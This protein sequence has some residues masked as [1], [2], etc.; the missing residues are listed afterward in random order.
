MKKT[1]IPIF[2]NNQKAFVEAYLI[3]DVPSDMITKTNLEWA[4]TKQ[5]HQ[6]RCKIRGYP[7]PE[8]SHWDWEKKAK[9]LGLFGMIQTLFGILC[10]DEIQGLM[11]VEQMTEFAKLPPNKGEPLL[12]VKFLEVAPQ[13]LKPY[14]KPRKYLGVGRLFLR[15]AIDF[16]MSLGCKGRVGLH[17]LPQAE[18]FYQT[19]GMTKLDHDPAHYNLRYFE[20]TSKQAHEYQK[21]K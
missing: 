17:A 7:C 15:V 18:M 6:D 8:H 10:Q 9:H 13:N 11:L 4:R 5:K 1:K 16:S 3:E 12:Y 20:F 2:D 19:N 21:R 14:A